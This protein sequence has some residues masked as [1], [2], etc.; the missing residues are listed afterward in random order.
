MRKTHLKEGGDDA[1]QG[2]KNFLNSSAVQQLSTWTGT[3]LPEVVEDLPGLTETEGELCSQELTQQMFLLPCGHLSCEMELT[4][5][6]QVRCAPSEAKGAEQVKGGR[7]SALQG[8]APR[9]TAP[10]RGSTP[11]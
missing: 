8:S 5:R 6:A 10:P 2:P 1:H 11:G 9:S 7:A 3:G 4:L